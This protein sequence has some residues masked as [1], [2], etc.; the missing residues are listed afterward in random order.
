MVPAA[1]VGIEDSDTIATILGGSVDYL[2][3]AASRVA[4]Q[5]GGRVIRVPSFVL[6]DERAK[7]EFPSNKSKDAEL[8]AILAAE[9]PAMFYPLA[10]R[11]RALIH[12]RI[13][14]KLRMDAMKARIG[15]EQ[16]LRQR[17]IGNVFTAADGLYP[18]EDFEKSFEAIKASDGILEGLRR[19]ERCGQGARSCD[20]TARRVPKRLAPLEGMDVKIAARMIANVVDIRQFPT[21]HKFVA[22]CGA[23]LLKDGRFARRR[24][25]ER[26]NWNNDCRQALYLFA[27]QANFRADSDL[28][29]ET[30]A[31]QST[32]SGETSRAGRDR[33]GQEAIHQGSHQEDG[34]LALRHRFRPPH[35]PRVDEARTRRD[36]GVSGSCITEARLGLR[37]RRETASASVEANQPEHKRCVKGSAS[38]PRPPRWARATIPQRRMF[39]CFL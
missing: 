17:H 32:L 9:K 1:Y 35:L 5:K 6:A 23:H 25:N 27:D 11:D 19:K 15:C 21:V 29:E 2:A 37:F 38:S 22:F 18:K 4:E 7:R 30:P 34:S 16:R 33:K 20:R 10:E 26:A 36:A 13:R 14:Y 3:F 12:A 8:L 39:D 31:D 24:N 28:G